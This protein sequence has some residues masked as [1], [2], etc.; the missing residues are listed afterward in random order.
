MGLG[1]SQ[2]SLGNLMSFYSSAPDYEL[3]G[4]AFQGQF[5]LEDYQLEILVS[6]YHFKLLLNY[7]LEER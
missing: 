2:G 1:C 5:I 3:G 4:S 6:S 7:F